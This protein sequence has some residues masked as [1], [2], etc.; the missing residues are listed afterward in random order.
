MERLE[1]QRIPRRVQKEHRRLLAD[2]A[3]EPRVRFDDKRHARSLYA[4]SKLVPRLRRQHHTEVRH[5]NIMSINR[6]RMHGLS[7]TWLQVSHNLVPEE[8]EVNPLLRASSFRAAKHAAIKAACLSQVVN[9]KR[10][11]KRT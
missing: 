9:R 6:I 3:L 11:M 5:G 4:R 1:L 10:K 7:R 8:V 2:L